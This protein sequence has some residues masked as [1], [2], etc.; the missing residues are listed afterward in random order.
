MMN[1]NEITYWASKL[2]TG[3][4]KAHRQRL[5][6]SQPFNDFPNACC[7]DAS[8][9]LAQYLKEN[10]DKRCQYQ[11]V[12]GVYR[13]DDFENIFGHAWLM[14]DRK[15]IVDITS[16]QRQFQNSEIF[17]QNACVPC[18]VAEE[19]KFHSLFEIEPSQCRNF[20]GIDAMGDYTY[21]RLKAI[22]DIIVQ[23]IE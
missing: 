7:G 22:Y 17:P 10:Y 1:I 18:F 16:D 6:R 4:E 2:R 15:I 11:Y 9:L 20:Y 8:D 23:N 14:I 12:Y 5:F 3:A 19:S 13:Y 21:T